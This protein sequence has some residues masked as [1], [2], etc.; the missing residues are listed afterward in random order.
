MYETS[1][2]N[3]SKKIII[4]AIS[5]SIVI[6]AISVLSI[7]LITQNNEKESAL[8]RAESLIN[9]VLNSEI[10]ENHNVENKLGEANSLI[11]KYSL[12]KE[13]GKKYD[14]AEKYITDSKLLDK[15][16]KKLL[17]YDNREATLLEIHDLFASITSKK[18]LKKLENDSMDTYLR[19]LE[20]IA[21]KY[22]VAKTAYLTQQEFL[23]EHP[24]DHIM[25]TI[26]I[27]PST[28]K[29]DSYDYQ[30]FYTINCPGTRGLLSG[31]KEIKRID[32]IKT[33]V[34]PD[35]ISEIDSKNRGYAFLVVHQDTYP[36]DYYG[37]T[38]TYY[39][40]G[41]GLTA[42]FSD[43]GAITYSVTRYKTGSKEDWQV[44][45]KKVLKFNVFDN[46][47]PFGYDSE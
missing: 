6:I 41:F 38:N 39:Y 19:Q 3:N 47:A 25:D 44:D 20:E 45:I 14:E 9:E 40:V 10:S 24:N 2:K 29:N 13:L 27:T 26:Y 34:V 32:N 31:E 23:S 17:N 18:V 8:T 7:I 37:S 46:L 12:K 36:Y 16:L 11:K 1:H 28:Y 4:L 33:H 43:T 5:I 35:A 42:S 22:V 21:N 30:G 15:A